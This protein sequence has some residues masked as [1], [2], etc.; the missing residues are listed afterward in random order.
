MIGDI[1]KCTEITQIR[2]VANITRRKISGLEA[3]L[4]P[5]SVHLYSAL[6]MVKNDP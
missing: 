5:S 4:G 6:N 2:Q 3:R 1:G